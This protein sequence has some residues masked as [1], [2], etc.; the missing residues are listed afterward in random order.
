MLIFGNIC[1]GL[2]AL[3]YA[4]PQQQLFFDTSRRSDSGTLAAL[5]FVLAPLWALL[6]TALCIVTARGGFDWL[7]RTR[8]PQYAFVLAGGVAIFVVAFF[9]LQA[10]FGATL[11]AM[12]F[13]SGWAVQVFPLVTLGFALLALN[14][15]LAGPIPALLP[16]LPLI[17]AAVMSVFACGRL[18]FDGAR[19]WG[20]L[21]AGT[22]AQ[23][24]AF[25]DRRDREKTDRIDELD[26]VE[27]FPELL[28]FT[29][30]SEP[31]AAREH[32]LKKLH[33]HPRFTALLTT[34]LTK[35][36]PTNALDYLANSEPPERRPLA[37]PVR[38]AIIR[39]A[40]LARAQLAEPQPPHTGQFDWNTH[41]IIAVAEKFRD[42]GVDYLPVIRE[43]RAALDTPHP[44]KTKFD[45]EGILDAWL[46]KQSVPATSK[47]QK[48]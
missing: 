4:I 47:A 12:R 41:L 33:A 10:R 3:I 7:T 11:P 8:A 16:R 35:T 18:V 14:P 15:S 19:F 5:I 37:E 1:L 26:V 36:A 42:E 48:S 31:T 13:F 9:S 32:A 20:D 6:T 34:A 38:R 2:A 30:G 39:L 22:A 40:A 23:K 21:K 45:A 46:A 24:A 28:E 43:F 25:V 17:A 27:D 44:Q 29:R